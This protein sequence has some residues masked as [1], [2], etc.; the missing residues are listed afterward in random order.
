MQEMKGSISYIITT[1]IS[2]SSICGSWGRKWMAYV[3]FQFSRGNNKGNDGHFIQGI[4]TYQQFYFDDLTIT[5]IFQMRRWKLTIVKTKQKPCPRLHK[6]QTQILLRHH[7]HR[8]CALL[9][10]PSHQE[11]GM[12]FCTDMPIACNFR[13][14]RKEVEWCF[15]TSHRTVIIKPVLPAARCSLLPQDCSNDPL[16]LASMRMC[17][18]LLVRALFHCCCQVYITGVWRA[19]SAMWFPSQKTWL[20]LFSLWSGQPLYL[21]LHSPSGS[22]PAG[23]PL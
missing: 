9:I 10:C 8:P 16:A 17:R 2:E 21:Q 19:L 1:C 13:A 4:Y 6:Q 22:L 14:D 15:S 18:E 7:D 12:L 11:C 20:I 23:N 3:S 5:L